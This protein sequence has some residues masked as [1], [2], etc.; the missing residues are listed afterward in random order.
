[1]AVQAAAA[2]VLA[3]KK[4]LARFDI[5]TELSGATSDME[6]IKSLHREQSWGHLPA[7]YTAVRRSLIALHRAAP[8]LSEEQKTKLQRATEHLRIMEDEVEKKFRV[9]PD[10]LDGP[11]LNKIVAG[12]QDNLNELL[13]EI[14]SE[15]GR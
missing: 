8:D 13:F 11:K 1:M 4:D 14:K 15:I 12:L 10:L 7:R 9:Q 6:E 2:A 5:V 3:V